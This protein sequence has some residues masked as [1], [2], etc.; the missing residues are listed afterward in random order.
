M[1]RHAST[2]D[3]MIGLKFRRRASARWPIALRLF[4]VFL[5]LLLLTA[6]L[7]ALGV[8]S[9]SYF[10]AASSQVRDRWL[11][12]TRVLGDLNNLTSDHRVAEASLLLAR[13]ARDLEASERQL[14]DLDRD[15]QGNEAIY[16]RMPRDGAQ[17]TL[18]A[19]FIAQWGEYQK[20]AQR[21]RTLA[22][23]G[24]QQ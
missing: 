7:G 5:F 23:A 1:S 12:S 8:A 11:P 13:D 9:L 14:D 22:I 24:D 21:V 3:V 18:H 10:N 2:G 6:L 4:L 15:I 19:R 16:S 20:I 17:E